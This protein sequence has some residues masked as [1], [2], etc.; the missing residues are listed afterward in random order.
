MVKPVGLK[1]QVPNND[2]QE[3]CSHV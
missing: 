2:D 1:G 3:L